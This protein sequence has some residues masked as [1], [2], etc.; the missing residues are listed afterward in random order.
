MGLGSLRE[1]PVCAL[2]A[3]GM[4]HCSA[5]EVPAPNLSD[6]AGE[7]PGTGASILCPLA[8]FLAFYFYL[9]WPFQLDCKCFLLPVIPDSCMDF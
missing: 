9:P 4:Q 8:S 5:L 1:V 2:C 3:P 6:G 7:P